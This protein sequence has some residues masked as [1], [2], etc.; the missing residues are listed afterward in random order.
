MLPFEAMDIY[1]NGEYELIDINDAAGKIDC[2]NVCCYP[3][4]IPEIIPGR[5]IRLTGLDSRFFDGDYY[6]EEVTHKFSSSGYITSFQI[7][8]GK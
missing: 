2:E 8:S 1:L 3:P 5:Y 6:I 4:G 7:G